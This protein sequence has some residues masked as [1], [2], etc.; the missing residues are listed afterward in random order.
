GRLV[1]LRFVGRR[2]EAARVLADDL[3]EALALPLQIGERRRIIGEATR[4]RDRRRLV[5]AVVRLALEGETGG[6]APAEVA[7]LVG[8]LV[9]EDRARHVRVRTALVLRLGAE[10]VLG[11]AL[12]EKRPVARAVA[13][14]RLR[15]PL[16]DLRL[17]P[18]LRL[19]LG[20]IRGTGRRLR[21]TR[22]R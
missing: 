8:A 15:V 7:L 1:G 5:V 4:V 22:E 3:D 12:P 6:D 14:R 19:P 17:V 21:R 16:I 11:L 10:A 20:R 13:L 9:E 2:H 18:L